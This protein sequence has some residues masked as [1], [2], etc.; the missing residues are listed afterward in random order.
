MCRSSRRLAFGASRCCYDQE[1]ADGLHGRCGSK[2]LRNP[3]A[4]E[5]HCDQATSDERLL[6]V[7]FVRIH[8]LG[9]NGGLACLFEAF[10]NWAVL[11]D[12]AR[13]DE[14]H[15]EGSRLFDKANRQFASFD[16]VER[17]RWIFGV[18]VA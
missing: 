6:V 1:D 2:P 17:H 4:F 8:P 12:F 15:L 11:V 5:L 7:A 3:G 18:F 9:A 14:L 13:L 10:G 16:V